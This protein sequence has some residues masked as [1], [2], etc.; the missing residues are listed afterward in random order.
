MLRRSSC[1]EI[2]VMRIPA[3]M[4]LAIG[5]ICA[6]APAR[7]QTYDP[8][9]PVCMHV[10]SWGN[11]YED[12]RYYTMEQCQASASGRSAT[13]NYNPFPGPKAL[14]AQPVRRH[15]RAG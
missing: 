11:D 10:N 8:D 5:M 3:S 13:C 1:K 9:F 15:R 14:Q 2:S 4:I 7:A 12:C 6:S